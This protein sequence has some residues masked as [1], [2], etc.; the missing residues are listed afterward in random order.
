MDVLSSVLDAM[1]TGRSVSYRVEGHAPWGR[2]FP[3][4]PGVALHVVVRGSCWLV[5]PGDAEPVALEVGDVALLPHGHAHGMADRPGRPLLPTGPGDPED[6]ARNGGSTIVADGEGIHEGTGFGGGGEGRE[7]S[8]AGGGSAGREPSSVLLC[9]FYALDQQRRHPFLTGLP[10]VILLRGRL[11]RHPELR[12]AV[13]LL[14]GELTEPR[15]GGDALLGALFDAM[16]LYS[17]RAW[18]EESRCVGGGWGSVLADPAVGAALR[19]MHERPGRPWTVRELG[20]V[21]GLSRAAFARRFGSMV[22]QSPMAYLTW[23]RMSLAARLL[24]DTAEPLSVVAE[25]VGYASEF[26]FAGAFRRE[27]GIPP[28]RYR[29]AGAAAVPP[30]AGPRPAGAAPRASGA[31]RA[32]TGPETPAVPWREGAPWR[33]GA[34]WGEAGP[35]GRPGPGR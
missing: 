7:P 34:P 32:G 28:G 10:Q 29:R 8:G 27:F 9:G 3:P 20:E 21:A 16:L 31:A 22:G 6:C 30:P 19:A 26:A 14:A 17:L 4:Q 5:P 11:G 25:R 13:D 15:L 33:G 23:W 2:A 1:R 35:G 12:A 24:L 18:Y